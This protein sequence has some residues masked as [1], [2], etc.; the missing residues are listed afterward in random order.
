VTLGQCQE[1]TGGREPK[2]CDNWAVT[3]VGGR[4]VCGQHANSLV[5]RV[6]AATREQRRRAEID[7]R[8]TEYMEWAETH[9]SVWDTR[10]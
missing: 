3:E 2:P 4:K 9:P 8:I 7:Q 10:R 1:H 5:I 6:D